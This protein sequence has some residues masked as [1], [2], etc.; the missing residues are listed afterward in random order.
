MRQEGIISELHPD[1][2]DFDVPEDPQQPPP[3]TEPEPIIGN[4]TRRLTDEVSGKPSIY[5]P[6]TSLTWSYCLNLMLR[7]LCLY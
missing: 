1:D 7:F 2:E 5:T 6:L 3:P 4:L